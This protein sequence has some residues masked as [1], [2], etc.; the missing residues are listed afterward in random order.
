M[1]L[2][3]ITAIILCRFVFGVKNELDSSLII[4]LQY[5]N[6]LLGPLT[7]YGP[8]S[9]PYD[10]AKDPILMTDWRQPECVLCL[11]SFSQ[12]GISEYPY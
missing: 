3:G 4:Y 1:G 12:Q 9:A 8:S 10:T 6:G 5:A 11:G 2:L 7:I